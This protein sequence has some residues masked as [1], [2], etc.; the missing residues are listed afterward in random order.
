MNFRRT[1]H[2]L[3]VSLFISALFITACSGGSTVKDETRSSSTGQDPPHSSSS[4]TSGTQGDW[5]AVLAAAKTEKTVNCACPPRPDFSKVLK[6]GFEAAYPGLTLET[7]AAPLPE[8][9]VRV[10]NEQKA[11]KYL[12]DVYMFGPGPEVYDLKNH[13]GF[14]PFKDYIVLPEIL[15]GSVYEGGLE[16]AFLDKEKKFI[17]SMWYQTND[18]G[19]NRN[20]LPDAKITKVEDLLD[21]KYKNQIVWVDPRGGGAG[22]NWLAYIYSKLGKDGIKTLLIDQKPLFVKGNQDLAEHLVRNSK[23]IG[24]PHTTPDTLIPYE[25]AGV[26]FNLES[27]GNDPEISMASVGGSSPAVF[28]NPPHP[29]ATKVFINWLLSKEAQELISQKLKQNSRRTDVTV[30]DPGS[31]PKKGTHY[32]YSQTEDGLAI[33]VEAQKIANELVP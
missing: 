27:A 31:V 33:R 22:S 1:Q 24:L 20:L 6:E 5:D 2:K 13:G 26:K 28:K 10:G 7:T 21:P 15:N 12:W 32:F 18:V 11:G 29:N 30:A 16:A 25:K 19:I 9:P 8:F 23:A 4:N 3:V 17:F 14:E